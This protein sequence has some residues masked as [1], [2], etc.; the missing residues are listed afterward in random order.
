MIR[1]IQDYS[2]NFRCCLQTRTTSSWCIHPVFHISKLRR[3]I[4]DPY[5]RQLPRVT[6]G[7]NWEIDSI[8]RSR[9]LNGRL[10]YFVTWR[11]P[12]GKT[13]QL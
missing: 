1:P 12:E 7:D 2:K 3:Y 4:P 8:D 9:L 13:E 10:E 5:N 6:R 11:L